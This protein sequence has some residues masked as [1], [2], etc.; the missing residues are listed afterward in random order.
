[1][2]LYRIYH[3]ENSVVPYK[4]ILLKGDRRRAGDFTQEE[5][6]Q[7]ELL[8]RLCFKENSEKM[9]EALSRAKR[10]ITDLCLCNDFDY[11]CTFEFNEMHVDRYNLKLCY[12]K[13]RKFFN[14]FKNR[15]APDFKYLIIPEFHPK[16]GA[17]HFHGLIAGMLKDELY[18][19]PYISRRNKITDELEQVPNTKR[20]MRWE[21]Y[22]KALGYFDCSAIKS[23]HA[24]AFYITKYVTKDLKDL[25]KGTHV[26]AASI[27]LKRPSLVYDEDADFMLVEP[28]FIGEYCKIA[29]DKY[30]ATYNALD[31]SGMIHPFEPTIKASIAEIQALEFYENPLQDNSGTYGT[32]C[33][34]EDTE[35]PYEQVTFDVLKKEKAQT[36]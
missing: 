14:N 7:R 20:Y 15:Y 12:Q 4:H 33:Y 8:R 3:Y 9:N 31:L 24:V 17:V 6:E 16:T 34:S 27:G 29:Y 25:P 23:R 18:I 28:S 11:F 22:S 2:G 21:R 30:E 10:I 36:K 5:R 26:Y 19:P 32:E 13:I 35:I 1:M